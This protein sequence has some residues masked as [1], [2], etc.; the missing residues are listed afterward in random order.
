MKQIDQVF[1]DAAQAVQASHGIPASITLAQWALESAWG[2]KHLG[3]H[4][5]FGMKYSEKRH[6]KFV[7]K[8]TREVINGKEIFIDAKFA[9][10]DSV[11]EGFNDRGYLLSTNPRYAPAMAVKSDPD[12]FAVQLQACGYATDPQYAKLLQKIMKENNLYQ[13]DVQS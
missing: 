7:I 2:A 1:I 4:N 10:F 8:K 3:S 13:Y 9:A 5:Y 11:E 6:K 12:A